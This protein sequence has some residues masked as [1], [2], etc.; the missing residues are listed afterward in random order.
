MNGSNSQ[1]KDFN[2]KFRNL[3]NSR[4]I[5][6]KKIIMEVQNFNYKIKSIIHVIV[7]AILAIINIGFILSLAR[8]VY[9]VYCAN[10]RYVSIDIFETYQTN[11]ILI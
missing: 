5:N 4:K 6:T 11:S 9:G 8:H 10:F 7:I 2:R 3:F 1:K